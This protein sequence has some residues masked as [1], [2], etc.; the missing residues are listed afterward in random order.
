MPP[1]FTI[2]RDAL[3]SVLSVAGR[4]ANAKPIPVLESMYLDLKAD[5]TSARWWATDTALWIGGLCAD[6]TVQEP[7]ECLV[8]VALLASVVKSCPPGPV[9]LSIEKDRL[10]VKAGRYASKLSTYPVGEFAIRPEPFSGGIDL[11]RAVT[12]TMVAQARTALNA[13]SSKYYLRGALLTVGPDAV[14]W[15]ATDG[16]R[17]ADA[18]TAGIAGAV[19]SAEIVPAEAVVELGR[20]LDESDAETLQYAWR[21]DKHLFQVGDTTIISRT[22]TDKF[23]AIDRVLASRGKTTHVEIDR[24]AVLEAIARALPT[25]TNQTVRRVSLEIAAEGLTI[26]TQSAA[27]GE[28]RETLEATVTG[29]AVTVIVNAQYL[30]EFFVVTDTARVALDFKTAIDPVFF[31]PIG[32]APSQF[33]YV[34]MVMRD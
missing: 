1:R 5:A 12:A 22:M 7:G 34:V 8:P 29:P 30:R 9:S 20:L 28:S 23:P 17:A 33:Q 21:N 14:M 13:Q 31:T 15:Q 18:R 3:L 6:V 4:V 26:T 24:E 11:P 27:L 25:S 19:A 16:H 2:E 10:C 32:D